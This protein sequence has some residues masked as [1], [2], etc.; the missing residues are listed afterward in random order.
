MKEF[1]ERFGSSILHQD[2]AITA[3]PVYTVQERRRIYGMDPAYGDDNWKWVHC[4]DCAEADPEEVVEL[5]LWE[6]EGK[7]IPDEWS[8]VYYIDVW[9]VVASFFL[10]TN[11]EQFM[12]NNLHNLNVPRVYVDSAYRNPE[13]QLIRKLLIEAANEH[14]GFANR[15]EDV[16]DTGT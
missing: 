4:D 3:E 1:V 10:L 9:E 13:W 5:N 12:A 2:N 8:K 14:G 7:L 11:A 15:M 6:E 16:D